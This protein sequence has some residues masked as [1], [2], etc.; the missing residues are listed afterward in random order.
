MYFKPLAIAIYKKYTQRCVK[1]LIDKKLMVNRIMKELSKLETVYRNNVV[2]AKKHYFIM[3]VE[4]DVKI[5]FVPQ[6]F[7]WSR[8]VDLC[9]NN[10]DL[11]I[12]PNFD[13]VREIRKSTSSGISYPTIV[14]I[15]G[16]LYTKLIKIVWRI[17]CKIDLL[18]HV[19]SPRYDERCGDILK[20]FFVFMNNEK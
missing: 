9:I 10:K 2:D 18:E 17:V 4:N 13:F 15:K 7:D 11:L 1:P 20:D 5:E 8:F 6:S 3:K 19:C 16:I 12:V 14:S